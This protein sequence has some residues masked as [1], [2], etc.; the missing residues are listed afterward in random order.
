MTSVE[1]VLLS[2]I[3]V[4]A[5]WAAAM[6]GRLPKA[7][8][9]RSC[10]GRAWR[11]AFPDA[12]KGEIREFLTMVASAFAFAQDQRLKLSPND[13]LLQIYRARYPVKDWPDQLELETLHR[14]MRN[15]YGVDLA[16]QWNDQV[17]LGELFSRARGERGNDV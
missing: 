12:P 16:A 13:Q 6:G 17:T 11:R 15:R 9:E 5:L 14:D 1:I 10:R 3:A 8:R 2:V 4:A 7:L